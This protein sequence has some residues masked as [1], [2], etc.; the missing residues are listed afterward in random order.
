M[1]TESHHKEKSQEPQNKTE[2]SPL[3]SPPHALSNRSKL[4]WVVFGLVLLILL[5]FVAEYIQKVVLRPPVLFGSVLHENSDPFDGAIVSANGKL[6][7]TRPDGKFQIEAKKTDTLTISAVG[8]SSTT[9]LGEELVATLTKLPTANA[10]VMVVDR[11]YYAVEKALVVRLD[12]NTSAP[13]DERITDSEGIATFSDILSGQA[14]F[15]VLHPD[16]GMAWI[17]TTVE[18]GGSPR[19]V[20][21]LTPLQGDEMSNERFIKAV[22][23]QEENPL[24]ADSTGYESRDEII[25]QIDDAA[26]IADGKFEVSLRSRTMVAVSFSHQ[27]LVNYINRRHQLEQQYQSRGEGDYTILEV[28]RIRQALLKE[29]YITP[30]T[31]IRIVPKFTDTSFEID[32]AVQYGFDSQTGAP[33]YIAASV[34]EIRQNQ[35]EITILGMDNASEVMGFIERI[36][37][38]TP[39]GGISSVTGWSQFPTTDFIKQ[40]G[41]RISMEFDFSNNCCT[42]TNVE[43]SSQNTQPNPITVKDLHNTQTSY[44]FRPSIA[45]KHGAG[46]LGLE[47]DQTEFEKFMKSNPKLEITNPNGQKVSLFD[48]ETPQPDDAPPGFLGEFFNDNSEA[49]RMFL[50][51]DPN[52]VKKWRDYLGTKVYDAVQK[53][54]TSPADIRNEIIRKLGLPPRYFEPLGFPSGQGRGYGTGSTAPSSGGNSSN[55][56][57]DTQSGSGGSSTGKEQTG[58]GAIPGTGQPTGSGSNPGC[59]EGARYTCSR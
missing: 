38:Q 16:Y 59:P 30:V 35:Y 4:K 33:N 53:G 46:Y 19:P 9:I 58:N 12:P 21:Q 5:Y 20:V 7:M 31:A 57:S 8:Y 54:K 40:N 45:E 47:R 34:D 11:E 17:E 56:A 14:A 3:S 42:V 23:A 41:G 48:I 15:V 36:R 55:D 25:Y 51:G 13:V 29:G 49:R 39:D 24:R 37:A 44:T 2:P 43:I 52:Y 27:T 22:Y 50:N 26:K 28:D 1:P 6:A 32:P 10:R 18:S